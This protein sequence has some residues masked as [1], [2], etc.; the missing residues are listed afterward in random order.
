MKRIIN[1]NQS[2]ESMAKQMQ[3]QIGDTQGNNLECTTVL[4]V[5]LYQ[6]VIVWACEELDKNSHIRIEKYIS[7]GTSAKL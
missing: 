2:L 5:L 1:K 6:L 7:Q 4:V 3:E